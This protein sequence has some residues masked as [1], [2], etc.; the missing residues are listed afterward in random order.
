M[1]YHRESAAA[2]WIHGGAA[3]LCTII[4]CSLVRVQSAGMQ[5]KRVD[6]IILC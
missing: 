6:Y 5:L 4:A 2:D 3:S 1:H